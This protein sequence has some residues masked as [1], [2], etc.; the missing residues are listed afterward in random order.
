MV[1]GFKEGCRCKCSGSAQ[2]LDTESLLDRM[3]RGP[4]LEARCKSNAK[5][6]QK[7][8]KSIARVLQELTFL[9]ETCLNVWTAHSEALL[10]GDTSL[11][12]A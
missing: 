3:L 6:M 11:V 2:R 1:L 5:A 4:Q 9:S 7:Q 10:L 8:S 12:F